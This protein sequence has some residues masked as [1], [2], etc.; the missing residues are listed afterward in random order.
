MADDVDYNVSPEQQRLQQ[1]QSHKH[2][3]PDDV[4]TSGGQWS[5][6][7]HSS[8]PEWEAMCDRSAWT[9][10][11]G[12]MAHRIMPFYTWRKPPWYVRLWRRVRGWFRR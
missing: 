2:P 6:I 1:L 12:A 3:T 4:D 8:Y 9:L 10:W 5:H 7:D 11:F